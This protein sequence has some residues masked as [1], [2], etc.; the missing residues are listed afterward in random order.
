MLNE[1]QRRIEAMLL[2]DE[3]EKLVPIHGSRRESIPQISISKNGVTFSASLVQD[4]G[5]PKRVI[6]HLNERTKQLIIVAVPETAED[7]RS[8]C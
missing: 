8:F 1:T 6:T 4:M 2:T 7:S 3:F 5:Y